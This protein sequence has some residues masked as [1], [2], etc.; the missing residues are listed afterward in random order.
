MQVAPMSR[1]HRVTL[2]AFGATVSATLYPAAT[3][4]PLAARPP[5]GR[6][7]V[8]LMQVAAERNA[9][10]WVRFYRAGLRR[11]QGSVYFTCGPDTCWSASLLPALSLTAV[12]ET[13]GQRSRARLVVDAA[14]ALNS[15][16]WTPAV[17]DNLSRVPLPSVFPGFDRPA[18]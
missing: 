5:S 6:N 15:T 3:T 16:A 7:L 14:R 9:A 2:Q 8:G 1:G 13:D 12:P 10:V 4:T 18:A 11:R 17:L